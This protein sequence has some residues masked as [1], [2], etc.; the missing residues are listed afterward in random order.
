MAEASKRGTLVAGNW[1]MYKSLDLAREL[2]QD[3]LAGLPAA[4]PDCPTVGFFPNAIALERVAESVDGREAQV[5]VGAQNMYCELEGAFT[6]EISPE[7]IT[8]AGGRGVLLGHSER[9][10]VFGEDDALIGKKVRLAVSA[11]LTAILCVGETIE[12]REAGQTEAVVREQLVE[13]LAGLTSDKEILSVIVA[14]EPVWAIGTGKTATPGQG[15]EVHRYL[16]GQ[17]SER[18]DEATGAEQVQILYGGSVKPENAG[19]LISEPDIDGFLVGGASL[20][21]DSFLKIC[22]AV[23]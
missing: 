8:S 12:Q 5:L 17:L 22:A 10:H 20:K 21:A 3:I 4:S 1:K 13:G 23:A 14:Y 9:R 15:Q 2:A 18:L 19:E 7:M 11:G 6:G 16:R